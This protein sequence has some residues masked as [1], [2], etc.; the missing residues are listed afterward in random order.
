MRKVLL[1]V[2][3]ALLFIGCTKT[4]ET[5]TVIE[6]QP[7]SK[8]SNKIWKLPIYF[9]DKGYKNL[10]TQ[11]ITNK[12]MLN[13]FIAKIKQQKNWERKDNFLEII[14]KSKID[15]NTENLI[16]YPFSEN[17]SVVVV[18]VDTPTSEDNH[19]IIKIGKNKTKE[20]N[21]KII[22]YALA[23][24]IKKSAKDI[25]FDDGKEKITITNSQN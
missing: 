15:F 23:Y 18:A 2:T 12:V 16:I 13:K 8:I 19:I 17:K 21:N 25:I 20:I 10:K 11:I 4:I 3:I 7:K 9:E 14:E 22:Y 5:V 6:V 1:T 24:K